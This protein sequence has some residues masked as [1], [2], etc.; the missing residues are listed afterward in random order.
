MS[1]SKGYLLDEET[2]EMLGTL[3]DFVAGPGFDGF[4]AFVEQKVARMAAGECDCGGAHDIGPVP[5]TAVR[6][7]VE[8]LSMAIDAATS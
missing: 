4:L 8:R 1:E 7:N 6:L 3:T 5:A 2:M